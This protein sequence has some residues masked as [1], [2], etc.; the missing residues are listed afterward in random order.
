LSGFG[1]KVYKAFANYDE[2]N[3]QNIVEKYLNEIDGIFCTSDVMAYA[4]LR[5]CEQKNI[6]IPLIGF[7]NILLSEIANITTIDQN[8]HLV[9]EKVAHKVHQLVLGEQVESEVISTHL[10]VRGTKKFLNS[11]KGG[12]FV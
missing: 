10:V 12:R 4:A 11:T 8:I 7:D 2:K 6:D 9:G 5:V 1:G 3:V